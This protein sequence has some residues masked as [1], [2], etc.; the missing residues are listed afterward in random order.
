M[1]DALRIFVALMLA[2]GC[3]TT[4]AFLPAYFIRDRWGEAPNWVIFPGYAIALLVWILCASFV[5]VI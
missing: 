5:D 4:F 2:V 1:G 3:L